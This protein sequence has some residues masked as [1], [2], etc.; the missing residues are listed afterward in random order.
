MARARSLPTLNSFLRGEIA[1][2]EVYRCALARMG[3]HGEDLRPCL[4][5]HER[6]VAMLRDRVEDLGGIP[7]EEPEPWDTLPIDEA[8]DDEATLTALEQGEDRGLK[9]YLDDVCKLDADS[10]RIVA[11]EI[12]PEQV[13]THGCVS[14][15]KLR[16]AG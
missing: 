6:R 5:S 11:R 15:L 9:H 14:D 7:A 16:D 4:A 13:R 2:V 8:G 10:R 1:A 3:E 12:L